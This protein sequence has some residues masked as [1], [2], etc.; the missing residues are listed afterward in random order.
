MRIE[1]LD[2]YYATGEKSQTKTAKYWAEIYPN[3]QLKQ[4]TISSWLK[5]EGKWRAQW[6]E[7]QTKGRGGDVKRVKQ[8]EH[9]EVDEMLELWVAKTM[10][11]GV[12]LNGEIIRQKWK[13]FADL[14]RLPEDERLHLS[15]GWLA[16]FKKRCGL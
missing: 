6:A 1:I 9:P 10:S 7:V 8:T 5:D 16:G 15:D 13:Q 3:L 11:N 4:P 2:W 12:L 14:V